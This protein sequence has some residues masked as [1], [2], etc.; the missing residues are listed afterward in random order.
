MPTHTSGA[1][2]FIILLVSAVAV[3]MRSTVR[4]FFIRFLKLSLRW[5]PDM[6][7]K[8]ISYPARGTRRSSMPPLLPTYSIFVSG[9]CSLR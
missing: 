1:K 2:S 9:S 6:V 5:K 4:R 7:I 3:K 8:A